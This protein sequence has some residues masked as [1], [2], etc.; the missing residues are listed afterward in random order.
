MSIILDAIKTYINLKQQ[1]GE[2]L[3]EFAKRFKAALEGMKSHL[4][5]PIKLTKYDPESEKTVK[6][7]KER[8]FS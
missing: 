4:E 5:G 7:C 3:Q 8:A 1:E 6:E 2:E